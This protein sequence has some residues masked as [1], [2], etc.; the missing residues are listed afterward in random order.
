[1]IPDETLGRLAQGDG[2]A[3]AELEAALQSKP[4][5]Q[6]E[7]SSAWKAVMESYL[8]GKGNNSA[9]VDLGIRLCD[10]TQNPEAREM[11]EKLFMLTAFPVN[12][13]SYIAII[14]VGAAVVKINKGEVQTSA[15]DGQWYLEAARKALIRAVHATEDAIKSG[16]TFGMANEALEQN[17]IFVMEAL[18]HLEGPEVKGELSFILRNGFGDKVKSVAGESIGPLRI[19]E[20]LRGAKADRRFLLEA[21][22]PD[23]TMPQGM[24][25]ECIFSAVETVYS[26][27][28]GGTDMAIAVRQLASFGANPGPMGELLDA[29]SMNTITRNVENALLHALTNGDERVRVDAAGGLQKIGSDRIEDILERIVARVG[30]GSET[31]ALASEALSTIRGGKVE[32]FDVAF[33]PPRSARPAPPVAKAR[34]SPTT[35]INQA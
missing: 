30:E 9:L 6:K 19:R 34:V 15:L 13:N 12:P 20:E 11:Y 8:S 33:P 31:G 23:P 32:I 24:F 35:N 10:I 26:P 4:P 21:A 2:S 5:T 17:V 3:V 28:A 22:Y 25:I 18:R 7:I 27:K 1:M 14:G 16:R 29:Q